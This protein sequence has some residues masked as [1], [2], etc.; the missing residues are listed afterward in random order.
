MPTIAYEVGDVALE[1]TGSGS[2]T[3][4]KIK[5]KGQTSEPFQELIINKAVT[6]RSLKRVI[7]QVEHA[8]KVL[9]EDPVDD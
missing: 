6:V 4:W 5:V 2:N 1:R 8:A 3:Q 7:G 9:G